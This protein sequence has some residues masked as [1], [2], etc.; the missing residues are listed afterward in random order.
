MKVKLGD[1]E[2]ESCEQEPKIA[3]HCFSPEKD[4]TKLKTDNTHRFYDTDRALYG[5]QRR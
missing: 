3:S 5:I 1:D 2:S 4:R